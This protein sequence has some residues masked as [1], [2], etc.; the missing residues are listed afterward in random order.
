ML[1]VNPTLTPADVRSILQLTATPLAP[2][3]SHEAGAGMLN[4]HAAVLK[5]AFTTRRI[6]TWRGTLNRGQGA[7]F[8]G[9]INYILRHSSAGYI[10]R[11]NSTNA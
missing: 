9:P 2:Y 6:G 8:Q 4:V 11:H 10:F 3:Y 1:E 5:A 7:V